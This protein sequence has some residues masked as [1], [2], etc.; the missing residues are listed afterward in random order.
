MI[1]PEEVVRVVRPLHR[2]QASKIRT[3]RVPDRPV[4]SSYRPGKLKYSR[5]LENGSSVRKTSLPHSMHTASSS[6]SPSWPRFR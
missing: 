6:G 2:L 4:P 3:K 1:E 5:S